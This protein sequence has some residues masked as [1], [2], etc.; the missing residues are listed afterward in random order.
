MSK[1]RVNF[2][3]K[4]DLYEMIQEIADEEGS[5]AADVFRKAVKKYIYF[6]K[7]EAMNRF[8]SS[9]TDVKSISHEEDK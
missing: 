9:K 6:Y 4:K 3:L 1:V 8:Y 2:H 7:T 5:S